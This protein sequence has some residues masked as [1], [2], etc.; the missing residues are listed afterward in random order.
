MVVGARPTGR[1][2]VLLVSLMTAIAVSGC[3]ADR[4]RS[5]ASDDPETTLP[6]P[7][8][9]PPFP[10][11]SDVPP[12]PLPSDVP[13]LEL[14]SEIPR[15]P[16]PADVPQIEL[17]AAIPQIQLP[18]AIPPIPFRPGPGNAAGATRSR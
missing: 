18:A 11:P 8:N 15:Q 6:V 10:F 12:V 13:V 3:G 17:P 4:G 2:A 1:R 5:I 9:L 14:P 16:L 7:V